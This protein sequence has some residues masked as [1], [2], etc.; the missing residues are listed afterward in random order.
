MAFAL[1]VGGA[2]TAA[3]TLTGVTVGSVLIASKWSLNLRL[4]CHISSDYSCSLYNASYSHLI[5]N[6]WSKWVFQKYFNETKDHKIFTNLQAHND[7]NPAYIF[8]ENVT[9]MTVPLSTST[10]VIQ[11]YPNY[12]ITSYYL[13]FRESDGQETPSIS[14]FGRKRSVYYWGSQP[15]GRDLQGSFCIFSGGRLLNTNYENA[16]E[17]DATG[18]PFLTNLV[19]FSR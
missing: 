11:F 18:G 10:S 7:Y 3:L 12:C 6:G 9:A 8:C 19:H 13:Y 1:I 4:Y 14:G 17:P 5:T 15:R 16:S 2:V